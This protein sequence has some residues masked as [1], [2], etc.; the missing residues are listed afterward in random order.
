MS[1]KFQD[2][3][4]IASLRAQWINYSDAAM[5]FVTICTKNHSHFFGLIEEKRMILNQLGVFV[6]DQWM[7][8]PII[9]PDMNITLGEF[10]VMPDHIHGIINIGVNQYN[11]TGSPLKSGLKRT[12]GPQSKSLGSVI[13]GFKSAVTTHA[14]KMG[15]VDFGWQTGY[16]ERIIRNQEEFF[17]IS[18]YIKN[19]V[20]TWKE[21]RND[22]I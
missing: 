1:N 16:H 9:R 3:Y 8:T 17:K 5:Y 21:D 19:N 20:K 6:K 22:S 7:E 14:R 18:K 15:M 4:R 13:R 12:F 11:L 10:I 2:K